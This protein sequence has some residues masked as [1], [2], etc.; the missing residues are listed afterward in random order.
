MENQ[1]DL[2]AFYYPENVI[3]K[4]VCPDCQSTGFLFIENNDGI[5]E[6]VCHYCEGKGFT[7]T[8]DYETDEYDQVDCPYCT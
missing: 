1:L 4:Q 2:H 7:E 6:P 3:E 5:H 8:M